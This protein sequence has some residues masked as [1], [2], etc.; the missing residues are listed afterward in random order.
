MQQNMTNSRHPCPQNHQQSG[1]PLSTLHT[2]S[3][4]A[5]SGEPVTPL[6]Q[7][8]FLQNQPAFDS[9]F[10]FSPF[11]ES[12]NS[13][14]EFRGLDNNYFMR[15]FV[16]QEPLTSKR[17]SDGAQN[18]QNASGNQ[19]QQQYQSPANGHWSVSPTSTTSPPAP[20]KLHEYSSRRS[21]TQ[22]NSN[23]SYTSSSTSASQLNRFP[24]ST[25][26][27]TTGEFGSYQRSIQDFPFYSNAVNSRDMSSTQSPLNSLPEDPQ[28]VSQSR[29][30]PAPFHPFHSF[31]LEIEVED[32]LALVQFKLA[33]RLSPLIRT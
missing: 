26:L 16:A 29:F 19:Y 12:C 15:E 17:N 27:T 11:D 9:Q 6:D 25:P 2:S 18:G 4:S 1:T 8:S 32:S 20:R 22:T 10:D 31:R 33:R 7:Y 14:G 24:E 30:S 21:S 5:T 23:L 28:W 3:T 13:E